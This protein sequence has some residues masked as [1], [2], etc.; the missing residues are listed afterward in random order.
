MM[1]SYNCGLLLSYYLDIPKS[2]FWTINWLDVI[3]A[4]ESSSK[5][6]ATL[7]NEYPMNI[8]GNHILVCHIMSSDDTTWHNLTRWWGPCHVCLGPWSASCE[9]HWEIWETSETQKSSA[10]KWGKRCRECHGDATWF[11]ETYWNYQQ[12]LGKVGPSPIDRLTDCGPG[13]V[14]VRWRTSA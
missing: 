9:T 1:L 14:K 11:I 2:R 13:P 10:E 3:Q 7:K 12:T 6:P 5:S 4:C 8:L